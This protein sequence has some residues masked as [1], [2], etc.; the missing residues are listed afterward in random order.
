M[1][2]LSAQNFTGWAVK[3]LNQ[4]HFELNNYRWGHVLFTVASTQRVRF[5]FKLEKASSF[6]LCLWVLIQCIYFTS[7]LLS[8]CSAGMAE[9][10]VSWSEWDVSAHFVPRGEG[11]DWNFGPIWWVWRVQLEVCPLLCVGRFHIVQ[12]FWLSLQISKR[13]R[14]SCEEQGDVAVL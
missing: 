2:H 8:F 10:Q 9:V 11:K 7:L 14:Y 3:G 1:G 6:K 4:P 13:C 12:H 5:C